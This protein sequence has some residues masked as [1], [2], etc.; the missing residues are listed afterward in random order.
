MLLYNSFSA[1]YFPFVFLSFGKAELLTDDVAFLGTDSTEQG[2][3]VDWQWED[4]SVDGLDIPNPDIIWPDAELNLES[5][6]ADPPDLQHSGPFSDYSLFTTDQSEAIEISSVQTGLDLTS[7]DQGSAPQSDCSSD[8]AG[9]FNKRQTCAADL[10][11]IRGNDPG[12]CPKFT[13]NIKITT[14]CCKDAEEYNPETY[15]T[16]QPC[17]QCEYYDLHPN[18]HF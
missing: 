2:S 16:Y 10:A 4:A 6:Y 17:W 9:M 15:P 3:L 18:W 7:S 5:S 14:C 8:S 13:N 12:L 11:K 1:L